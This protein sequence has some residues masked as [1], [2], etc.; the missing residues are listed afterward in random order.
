MEVFSW[1]FL[2]WGGTLS[3]TG[4]PGLGKRRLKKLGKKAKALPQK[5]RVRI[6]KKRTQK[7]PG[8]KGDM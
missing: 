4:K 7:G 1:L 5:L 3:H 8:R 6:E 2:V